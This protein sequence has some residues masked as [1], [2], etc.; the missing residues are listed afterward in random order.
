MKLVIISGRSGSGKS[1]ALHQLED[2][3]YYCIDNLPAALL[4]Q[5]VNELMQS[6]STEY[7]LTAACIDA[8]NLSKD[9][10]DFPQLIETLPDSVSVHTLFLDAQSA[11]LIK[12][13]S[14]TRRK[15][16]LS[17][18]KTTLADAIEAERKMLDPIAAS[19][20]IV[21]DTTVMN[22]YQLRAAIKQQLSGHTGAKLSILIQSFGFKNGVPNDADF[23]FDLRMLPN[24]HWVK[25]L[26]PQ[27]GKEAEVIEFLEKEPEVE[28]MFS[29]LKHFLEQ[30]LPSFENQKRS[31]VTIGIGCTGGRHRSVYM[32]D[33]LTRELTQRFGNVMARHR[34]IKR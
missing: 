11:T 14:E 15:H 2:D 8:R 34:D 33:R 23:V 10:S 9:L 18:P 21:I 4:P 1:T 22:I 26:R 20:N 31:Y 28:K 7:K 19:A 25:P 13:F 30:W 17:G 5:L 29:D 27:S 3:G 6:N 32:A 24:P 12:R 16:P